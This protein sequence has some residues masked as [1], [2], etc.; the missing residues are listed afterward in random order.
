MYQNK[1]SCNLIFL[2]WTEFVQ[3]SRKLRTSLRARIECQSP[4]HCYY[5]SYTS[6]TTGHPKAVMHSHDTL[7]WGMGRLL[8]QCK[9]QELSHYKSKKGEFLI[10]EGR[11]EQREFSFLPCCHVAGTLQI[12]GPIS[13]Q[14]GI[15]TIVH[16]AAHDLNPPLSNHDNFVSLLKKVQPTSFFWC[17]LPRIWEKLQCTMMSSIGDP[18]LDD[19]GL[20]HCRFA[21]TGS[22]PTSQGI[23]DFFRAV[24]GLYFL[25]ECY[26]MTE[27][28]SM[29][30]H[31]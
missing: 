19:V 13:Q 30:S 5:L 1:V 6:G 14:I 4:G 10:I 9:T 7:L 11:D 18:N 26:A 25:C 20:G 3:N 21:T 15:N 28:A 12:I 22:A 24:V 16:F 8:S 27:N 2:T 23:F 31:L 29:Y 17:V